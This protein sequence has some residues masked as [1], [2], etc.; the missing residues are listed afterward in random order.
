MTG[1]ADGV[2]ILY[3]QFRPLQFCNAG[4]RARARSTRCR[5][6]S[7]IAASIAGLLSGVLAESPLNTGPTVEGG[8]F[9]IGRMVGNS[10][11][12]K[13]PEFESRGGI[14]SS[15]G[16]VAS[17]SSKLHVDARVLIDVTKFIDRMLIPSTTVAPKAPQSIASRENP[18]GN[19]LFFIGKFEV[20][21]T[22]ILT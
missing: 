11:V 6:S 14:M 18:L 13:Y 8:K 4:Y 7:W 2:E 9:V 10:D 12:G 1:D 16:G 22:F 19:C 20:G 21:F 5:F 15:S 17:S 3:A